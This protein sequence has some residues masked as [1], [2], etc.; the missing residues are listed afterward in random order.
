M[1]SMT[2]FG[3]VMDLGLGDM[4]QNQAAGETEEQRR[5]RMQEMEQR[6]LMGSSPATT[7]LF[8]NPF[9]GAGGFNR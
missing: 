4:L 3:A 5:K 6:R 7:A 9:G 2:D 8:G 1:P